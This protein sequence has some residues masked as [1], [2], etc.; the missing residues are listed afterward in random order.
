MILQLVPSVL[1]MALGVS[2]YGIVAHVMHAFPIFSC[3]VKV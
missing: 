2:F 1:V 3:L